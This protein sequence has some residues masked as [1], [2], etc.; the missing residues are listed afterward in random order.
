MRKLC[1][2]KLDYKTRKIEP[3]TSLTNRDTISIQLGFSTF[4]TIVN[5]GIVVGSYDQTSHGSSGESKIQSFIPLV[6]RSHDVM[7]TLLWCPSIPNFVPSPIN[8]LVIKVDGNIEEDISYADGNE[9]GISASV[10]WAVV[11]I[12]FELAWR[13][14]VKRQWR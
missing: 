4:T 1:D 2:W 11:C 9:I 5:R 6:L 8:P 13:G 10:A 14:R 7:L 3:A 12:S